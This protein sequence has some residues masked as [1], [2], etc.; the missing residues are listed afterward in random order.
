LSLSLSLSDR[1]SLIRVL[2]KIRQSIYS[3]MCL[4]NLLTNKLYSKFGMVT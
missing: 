3:H 1:D 2:A 4:I